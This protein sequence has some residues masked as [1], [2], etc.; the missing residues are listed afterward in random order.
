VG[1]RRRSDE[2]GEVVLDE[3]VE[4]LVDAFL[5]RRTTT[6]R[7]YDP[8]GRLVKEEVVVEEFRERGAL[9]PAPP[10]APA[11]KRPWPQEPWP[12]LPWNPAPVR[13]Q[14]GAEQ[15]GPGQVPLG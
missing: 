13:W 4:D 11:P 2:A 8:E 7:H 15:G 14:D 1:E 9:T 12:P 6:S 10:P 3:G 5:V